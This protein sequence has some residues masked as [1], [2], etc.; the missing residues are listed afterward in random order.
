MPLG[1]D[2]D[3]L[4]L[5]CGVTHHFNTNLTAA[6]QY[7]FYNYAEPTAHGYNDYTAHMIFGTVTLRLP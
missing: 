4:G 6:L 1:I 3:L 5:Q 2:Y 7:G